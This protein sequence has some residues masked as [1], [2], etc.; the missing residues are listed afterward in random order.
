MASVDNIDLAIFLARQYG[1]GNFVFWT[2][3]DW[4]NAYAVQ[5]VRK[6]PETVTVRCLN[7]GPARM[8][9]P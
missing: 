2:A 9:P 8:T 6:D 5:L 1:A 3:E 4:L 7:V